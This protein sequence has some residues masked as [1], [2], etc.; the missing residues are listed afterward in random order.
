MCARKR[1]QEHRESLAQTLRTLRVDSN[2]HATTIEQLEA[3]NDELSRQLSAAQT[4]ERNAKQRLRTAETSVKV[5]REDA[6]RL[7]QSVQQIRSSCANDIRKRDIQLQKLKTHLTEQQRGNRTG[8]VGPTITVSPGMGGAVG[9]QTIGK[10]TQDKGREAQDSAHT[11]QQETTA[12]LTQLSQGLSDENDN[13]IGLVRSTLVTLKELQGLPEKTQQPENNK[14]LEENKLQSISEDAEEETN[15]MLEVLPT[16]CETVAKDMQQVLDNL[17]I[18]LTSPNFV[19]IEEVQIRD[20]EIIKLREGWEM[21]EIRWKEALGMMNGWRQKMQD[22]DAVDME[23]LKM[24]LILGQGLS[25]AAGRSVDMEERLSEINSEQIDEANSSGSIDEML[26]D[27]TDPE[28]EL[29]EE[30]N[31]V[32]DARRE[33]SKP[34][35]RIPKTLNGR[36]IPTLE[37]K[38]PLVKALKERNNNVGAKLPSPRKVSFEPDHSSETREKDSQNV[39]SAAIN[40]ELN[41]SGDVD[42]VVSPLRQTRGHQPDL[43]SCIKRT[44]HV[45]KAAT[46]TGNTAG[47]TVPGGKIRPVS[48]KHPIFPML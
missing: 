42:L 25:G 12:F 46:T 30:P 15:T 1:E 31:I 23:D 35:S 27:F 19:P 33:V 7:K 18:I 20:E 34:Q 5:L 17:R 2:Q 28:N 48:L 40:E 32:Q 3:R 4:Q 45:S 22:G 6:A 11:L 9:R 26:E 24:G 14:V 29:Q 8:H 43:S 37:A 39:P 21:M 41:S 47:K 13:L 10:D 36:L 16:N 38:R 44:E